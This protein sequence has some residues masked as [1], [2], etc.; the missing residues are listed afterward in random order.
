M[1]DN[2]KNLRTHFKELRSS[3]NS[4]SVMAKSSLISSNLINH[5]FPLLNFRHKLIGIYLSTKFEVQTNQ[6]IKYFQEKQ[7]LFATPK[8]TMN[9]GLEFLLYKNGQKFI[10]NSKYKNIIE[11]EKGEVGKPDVLILPLLAFDKDL[12]RL[13][14]GGGF[15][16][17]V[18]NKIRVSK[19]NL[20][21]IGL[22]FSFQKYAGILPIQDFDQSLDYVV[23][24][25][26][27][28]SR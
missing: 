12:N 14:M 15:Y 26:Q 8:V 7:I 1:H 28:F 23:C 16:D 9:D 5:V 10:P 4:Q 17:K 22:A 19:P 18:I 3:H 6:I 24:E 11:V 21:S 25:D 27:I 2:K 13:G 20:V